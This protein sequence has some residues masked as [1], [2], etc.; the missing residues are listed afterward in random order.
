MA[1][2]Q[3]NGLGWLSGGG[4]LE[5]AGREH[6]GHHRSPPASVYHLRAWPLIY[7]TL[8][9]SGIAVVLGMVIAVL[10]SIF[11]VELAPARV[12][13]VVIPMVRLLASVPR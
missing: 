4:D 7:G 3:H 13:R 10:S 9:T 5:T 2:L 12:S 6:A 8:L 11:I 1:D